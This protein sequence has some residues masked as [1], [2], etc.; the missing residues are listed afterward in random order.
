MH[1][2]IEVFVGCNGC[3]VFLI[4]HVTN[5]ERVVSARHIAQLR[6]TIG[7]GYGSRFQWS[8]GTGSH[9]DGFFRSFFCHRNV[10]GTPRY[11]VYPLCADAQM[12][13]QQQAEEYEKE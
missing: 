4:P 6:L 10:Y 9:H 5:H 13:A 12:C 1:G 7:I 2:Q 11:V 8:K 3:S